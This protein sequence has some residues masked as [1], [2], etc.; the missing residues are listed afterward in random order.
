MQRKADC[1]RS[2][3][4]TGLQLRSEVLAALPTLGTSG[5]NIRFAQDGNLYVS[6][7]ATNTDIY[8]VNTTKRHGDVDGEAVG[9]PYLNAGKRQFKY[10][11]SLR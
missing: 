6:N 4:L 10:V 8:R 5:Q 3:P 7:T 11:R 9:Y 1:T 2:I